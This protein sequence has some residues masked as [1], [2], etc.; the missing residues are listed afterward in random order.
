MKRIVFELW[1][2]LRMSV[3]GGRAGW[4]RL[5]LI[6]TGV[7]L[8]VAV[9][10]TVATLP[11]ALSASQ[12]R[13]HARTEHLVRDLPRDDNTMLIGVITTRHHGVSISGRMVQPE[14][15][16]PPLP[17]GISALPRPGEILV[18]PAL[19][20]LM[21]DQP[22]LAARWNARVIGTIGDDGLSGPAELWF[23]LGADT[24]TPESGYRI[25]RFGDDQPNDS[26]PPLLILLAAVGIVVLL[27]PVMV[28]IASA[29]RF[30]SEVRDQ[31]LAALRLIGTDTVMTRRIAAGETLTG[32]VLGLG[33]GA[34]LAIGVGLL[35]HKYASGALSFYPSD[36]RPVP[37]LVVLIALLVPTIAV[38][39]TLTALRR[40]A[41][42]PLGVVR[43]AHDV[44]RR[45]WW[46]L[47]LPAIG[48]AL[49]WTIGDDVAGS[50]GP[51]AMRAAAGTAILL[52]G[53][54]LLLPWLVEAVVR[55]LRG[56]GLPWQLAV[57]RLQADSSTAV[58]AVSGIVVSL[59][60]IIALQGLTSGI[61]TKLVGA[62]GGTAG[63]SYTHQ[64]WPKTALPEHAWTAALAATPGVRHAATARTIRVRSGAT[65]IT[66][67]IGDCAVLARYVDT[68]SCTN[69]DVYGL[70]LPDSTGIYELEHGG[71]WA[72]PLP[73]R[74]A[75]TAEAANSHASMLLITSA[76]AAKVQLPK[77]QTELTYVVRLDTGDPAYLERLRDTA[78]RLDPQAQIVEPGN[79]G[80]ADDMRIARQALLVGVVMLL[81]LIGASLVV[82]VA[83]QLRERRKVLAVLTA[84]GTPR[85]ILAGSILVQAGI[86]VIIGMVLAAGVGSTLAAALMTVIHAPVAIDWAG[87]ATMG[88]IAVLVVV[89]A[90][91][92][93]MPTLRRLTRPRNLRSE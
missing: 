18:S 40:V 36:L 79:R 33:A 50:S 3:A 73:T 31:R 74:H 45:L 41:V 32:A 57:R 64:I 90:A 23:Y 5:A 1:L 22:D 30:G 25:D 19:A 28:F 55:R 12:A 2:G 67:K 76:A 92:A 16:R 65:S 38:S 81:L 4:A 51:A 70:N 56:G 39:A 71:T 49:L 61:E 88:S 15:S 58:R 75:S 37:T 86:P 10:L 14:G 89:V 52:V 26:L 7:G 20:D 34:F 27:V 72:A 91:A 11:A 62:G 21:A 42:E 35:A 46:R 53:L 80:V 44:R 54:A 83:E 87:V 82:N 17:P 8:G 66:I 9:L 29:V 24:L 43:Q 63:D 59:A 47:P 78:A 85:R 60:G 77:P 68:T 69:G 13:N 93:T 6:A 48:A 84:I